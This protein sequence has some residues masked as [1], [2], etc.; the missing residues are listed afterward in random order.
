MIPALLEINQRFN[1][2][3][4]AKISLNHALLYLGAII[5]SVRYG[6]KSFFMPFGVGLSRNEVDI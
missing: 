1:L 2:I 6:A 4:G 5:S 3:F